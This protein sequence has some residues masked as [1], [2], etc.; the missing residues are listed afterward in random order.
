MSTIE[1]YAGFE[2]GPIRPPSE[3]QSL[4]LRVTRNCPWNKCTFC[5]LYKGDRFSARPVD[6]LRKDIDRVRHFVDEIEAAREDSEIRKQPLAALQVGLGQAD[7]M[8]FHTAL[9]FM[10]GGMKS[11]F[12]Q[13]AN[14]LVIRPD[15]LVAI[16]KHLHEAFPHIERVTSYARSHTVARIRDE[17]LERLAAAGLNR[18]HIGMESAA[19]EV[20]AFVRKGVNKQT[21]ILA[22]QKVVRAG[23]EL[24]EYFMPGLGGK[25]H[26]HRNALETADALNQI[27][28][29]FIRI[30]TLAIPEMLELYRDVESGDFVPL[31]DREKAAE[32]LLFLENLTGIESVVKSDHI[33]NLFQEVEGR[34]PDDQSG[35]T[36]PLHTFLSL[37]PLEQMFYIVGRRTGIFTRL[38]DMEDSELC[39]HTEKALAA[40]RVNLNNLED[41]SAEMMQNFI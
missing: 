13:D 4:L 6:H 8:A 31:G 27:N 41:W 30:R 34:L 29:A 21:H 14:T 19:D 40:H 23:I 35:M 38:G 2:L 15:D 18:I 17:D 36:E 3:A 22:G 24:S 39:G 37:P 28:P 32:L 20:L 25:E 12:L 33:L 26:S 9:T 10:R 11:I 16:L 1:P 5:G 7:Q